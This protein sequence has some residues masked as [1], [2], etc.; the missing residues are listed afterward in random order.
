MRTVYS[1]GGW[2]NEYFPNI[3]LAS[4]EKSTYQTCRIKGLVFEFACLKLE[5]YYWM[6]VMQ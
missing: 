5:P 6:L 3:R 4:K 1:N 2:T